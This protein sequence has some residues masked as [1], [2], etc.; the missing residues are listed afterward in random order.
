MPPRSPSAKTELQAAHYD[1]EIQREDAERRRRGDSIQSKPRSIVGEQ[2]EDEEPGVDVVREVLEADENSFVFTAKTFKRPAATKEEEEAR[3]RRIGARSMRF[4]VSARQRDQKGRRG[5]TSPSPRLV[6]TEPTRRRGREAR[7]ATNRR[8]RGSRRGSAGGADPGDDG[9]PDPPPRV[10]P[11]PCGRSLA[12]RRP[13]ARYY[14]DACR[15]RV[16]RGADPERRIRARA[17]TLRERLPAATRA[18]DYFLSL[19]LPDRLALIEA[20][21]I[22]RDETVLRLLVMP[23]GGMR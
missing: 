22:P 2:V 16:E 12:G 5:P 18:F 9:D 10:C 21:A 14:E 11:C 6:A 23:V 8:S 4:L 20:R 3:L 15:K 19:P 7:P 17:E 1:A 13:Q